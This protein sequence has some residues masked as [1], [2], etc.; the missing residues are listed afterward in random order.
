MGKTALVEFSNKLCREKSFGLFG[1][2]FQDIGFVLHV[3]H[4]RLANSLHKK[5]EHCVSKA[6]WQG[7]SNVND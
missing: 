7:K 1:T 4:L 5:H 3:L 2:V 6:Q